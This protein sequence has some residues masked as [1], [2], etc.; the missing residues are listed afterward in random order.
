MASDRL[1]RWIR[2]DAPFFD[3]RYFPRFYLKYIVA[4]IRMEMQFHVTALT[5]AIENAPPNILNGRM[6]KRI[7]RM[8]KPI[9]HCLR[10]LPITMTA[11]FHFEMNGKSVFDDSHTTWC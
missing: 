10:Q 5:L 2:M 3:P 4:R 7:I 9:Q 8:K 6:A 1:D 11:R